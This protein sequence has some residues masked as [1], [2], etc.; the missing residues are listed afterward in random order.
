ML[1]WTVI[2]SPWSHHD[3]AETRSS[4]SNPQFRLRPREVPSCLLARQTTAPF[5]AAIAAASSIKNASNFVQNCSAF[6]L[7]SPSTFPFYGAPF[8]FFLS[9]SL[10]LFGGGGGGEG[11]GGGW[12]SIWSFKVG[13]SIRRFEDTVVWFALFLLHLV[14]SVL[15]VSFYRSFSV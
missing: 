1:L 4:T 6:D 12:Y 7:S 11:R 5:S 10:F 14:T 3:S 13:R 15:G 8:L 9:L 2:E